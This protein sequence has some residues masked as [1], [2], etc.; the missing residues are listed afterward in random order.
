MA[1]KDV[2]FAEVQAGLDAVIES[3]IRLAGLRP[4]MFRGGEPSLRQVGAPESLLVCLQQAPIA[5]TH[6]GSAF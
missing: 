1:L 2:A 3:V 5:L 4:G 6:S